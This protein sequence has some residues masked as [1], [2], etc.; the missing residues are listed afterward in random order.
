MFLV[1]IFMVLSIGLLLASTGPASDLPSWH[2]Y[3]QP[4]CCFDHYGLDL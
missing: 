3:K 2:E 1:I 4:H